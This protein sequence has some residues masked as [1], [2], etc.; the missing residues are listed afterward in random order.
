MLLKLCATLERYERRIPPRMGPE[1]MNIK[2]PVALQAY[3]DMKEVEDK[4]QKNPG[5]GVGLHY[6][7]ERAL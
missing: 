1:N 2:E 7:A 4:L 3:S 5:A 6:L